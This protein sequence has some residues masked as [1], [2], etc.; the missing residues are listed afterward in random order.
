MDYLLE[1]FVYGAG[2]AF[3]WGVSEFGVEAGYHLATVF[4]APYD[5]V[6]APVRHIV[7]VFYFV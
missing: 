5:V 2:V 7:A 4:W 3:D 1:A 6:V